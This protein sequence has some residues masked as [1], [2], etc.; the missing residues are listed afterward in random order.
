MTY[1]DLHSTIAIYPLRY[2]AADLKV[3][4]EDEAVF[5]LMC[6]QLQNDIVI[7]LRQVIQARIVDSDIEPLRLA[8]ATAGMMNI[9]MLA[10]RISEGW[11]LIK[12]RFQIIFMKTYGDTIDQTA[13]NDLAWLKTYFSNSNLVRQVRDNAVAHFD[14]KMALEGF[15]RLKAEEPMIDLHAREEGNTIFFSAESLML[16]SLH[17]MVGTDEPLEALNRIGEEVIDIT[18]KLGNVV[19]AYLKAFSQRHL[20]RHLEG[21]GAEK[22]LIEGQPKLSTFTAP[23][24]LAVPRSS[25]FARRLFSGTSPSAINWFSK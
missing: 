5:F 11:K 9:R 20:A 2:T 19:R 1:P 10:A 24:Y 17:H 22:I 21:L 14:P 16:S 3:V 13:K 12:D 23:I 15:R 4:P 7:L 18:R 6:G 8:A 25:G